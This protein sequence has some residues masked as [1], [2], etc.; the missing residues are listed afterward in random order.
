[1]RARGQVRHDV[2]R[3]RQG[4]SPRAR[5]RDKGGDLGIVSKGELVEAL[6]AAIFATPPEEYPAPVLL[7]DSIHLF[8]VTD[9][10]PPGFKP[11]AEV[12]DDLQQA[13]LRRPLRE[14]L[15]RV[16]R[17]AAP[18]GVREDLRAGAREA[19]REEARRAVVRAV[20]ASRLPLPRDFSFDAV[21][22]SHGWY[23]LPPFSYD[24]DGR[25]PDA[26]CAPRAGAAG[27]SRRV[28]SGS[29]SSGARPAARRAPRGDRLADLLARPRP[30]GLRRDARRRARASPRPRPRR[31][32]DAPRAD[33]LRGRRQDAP[34]DQLLVGGDA[35]AWWCASIDA[36]G[37]R[38]ARFP[39][40]AGVA[41]LS[42]ARAARA[43]AL[44][45][46]RRRRSR[47][48]RAASTP[49]GSISRSGSGRDA[50]AE[51]VRDGDPGRARLRTVRGG[52]TPAHSRPP[53]VPR[54]RFVGAQAV[55]EA[56]SGPG[57][58]G[59]PRDRA[60][61][62]ALRRATAGSRCG[63]SSRAD[64]HEGEDPDWS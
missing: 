64:W 31:R 4:R 18:R 36:R 9:R 26:T 25:R 42:A 61:V 13:D 58:D 6:D 45:L 37:R 32:P 33:A 16:P 29:R 23:D 17:Q 55:P 1:M 21:V 59:G 2:R 49:A 3:P 12:K 63:S 46:S 8:H 40:P 22:R 14:A 5:P 30:L 10:K 53:R 50:P 56:P 20:C 47:A 54:A 28:R 52:G 44:R 19:R 27:V 7:P 11:F 48:S 34:H 43:R 24:R 51:A 35:R 38:T 15:H 60:P 39:A 57:E 41:R 62:R